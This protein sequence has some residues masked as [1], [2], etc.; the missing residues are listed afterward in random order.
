MKKLSKKEMLLVR[1]GEQK[2]VYYYSC[3]CGWF[4][5]GNDAIVTCP[6]CGR[7]VWGILI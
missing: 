4:G 6:H 3:D 1:A 7:R 2:K 5:K